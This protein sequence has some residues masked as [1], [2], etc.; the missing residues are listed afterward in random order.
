[1]GLTMAATPPARPYP[2]NSFADDARPFKDPAYVR[3]NANRRNK[4]V[5]QITAGERERLDKLAKLEADVDA[6]KRES[7]AFT[8]IDAP[9]S[10]IPAKRYCDVTGLEAPY[11]DPK[12]LIRYHNAEIYS[13]VIKTLSPSV[14]QAYLAV[15]RRQAMIA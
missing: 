5:K 11:T 9:P 12:A 10:L 8:T 13:E 6:Y 2:P 1:M 7:L 3:R 15:R 14:V 4:T